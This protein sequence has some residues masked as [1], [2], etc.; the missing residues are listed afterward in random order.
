M[1]SHQINY[2]KKEHSSD[3][4]E[5]LILFKAHTVTEGPNQVCCLIDGRDCPLETGTEF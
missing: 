2:V 1:L 3:S 5:T 4:K